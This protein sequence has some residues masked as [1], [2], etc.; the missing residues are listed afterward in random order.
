MNVLH[1]N[2][3][4]IIYWLVL[5]NLESFLI[6]SDPVPLALAAVSISFATVTRHCLTDITKNTEAMWNTHRNPYMHPSEPEVQSTAW[7]CQVLPLYP[8]THQ[9]YP[10]YCPYA[11]LSATTS[12]SVLQHSIE[13]QPDTSSDECRDMPHSELR[14]RIHQGIRQLEERTSSDIQEDRLQTSSNSLSKA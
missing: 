4:S 8:M 10:E 3:V 5:T 13:M 12:P 7:Q 2:A 1:Q 9:S 14:T 11:K 6:S